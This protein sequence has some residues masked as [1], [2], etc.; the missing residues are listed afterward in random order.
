[1]PSGHYEIRTGRANRKH[2]LEVSGLVI[3]LVAGTV[4]RF[5]S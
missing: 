2:E 4:Y 5:S 1:M 3:G